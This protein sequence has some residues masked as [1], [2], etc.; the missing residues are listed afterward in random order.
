[1][2]NA[3]SSTHALSYR[4]TLREFPIICSWAVCLSN[5]QFSVRENGLDKL[6]KHHKISLSYQ[7]NLFRMT[8]LFCGFF[9]CSLPLIH[10]KSLLVRP[11]TNNVRW[12]VLRNM[13]LTS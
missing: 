7:D 6:L 11:C 5:V 2:F 4:S 1:M 10:H 9:M 8:T 13:E 12:K 3:K